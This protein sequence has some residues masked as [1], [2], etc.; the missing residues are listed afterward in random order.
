MRKI[1][2]SL[3]A[4]G[5]ALAVA[6]PAAAQFYPQAQGYGQPYG[7]SNGYNN[8]GQVRALQ[9]RLNNLQWQIQRSRDRS[10]LRNRDS[11][12]LRDQARRIS[13]RLQRAQRFGLNP[14]EAN[15]IQMRLSQLEQE[16]RYTAGYNGGRGYNGYNGYNGNNGYYGNRDNQRDDRDH[17]GRDRDDD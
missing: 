12:R 13:D 9:A 2:L 11:N 1:V 14:M 5:A 17:D 6:G 16:V 8:F 15:D 10:G 4:A 3:A 7:Y